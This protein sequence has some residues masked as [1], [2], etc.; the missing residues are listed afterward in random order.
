MPVKTIGDQMEQHFHVSDLATT[1]VMMLLQRF[2]K[3]GLIRLD[4][5]EKVVI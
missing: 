3:R 4:E 5:M 1:F 2:E